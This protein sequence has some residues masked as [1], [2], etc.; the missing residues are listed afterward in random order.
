MVRDRHAAEELVQ[1]TFVRAWMRLASLRNASAFPSWLWSIGRNLA[2]TRLRER[3]RDESDCEADMDRH[4]DPRSAPGR[5]PVEWDQSAWDRL[6]AGLNRD[7]RLLLELRHVAG[8]SLREIGAVLGIPEQRVK[9]RLFS[10]RRRLAVQLREGLPRPLPHGTIGSAAFLEETIMDIIQTQRLGAHVFMRLSLAIQSEMASQVIQGQ[11][12]GQSVLSAIGQV[13][14]GPEFIAAYGATITLPE[15]IGILNNVDRFTER[16][17]V[18]H[19]EVVAPDQAE[20]IKQNM[21]VFE[22]IVLFDPLAIRLLLREADPDIFVT[23]LAG[24]E[25]KVRT[26]VLDALDE[27]GR[28]ELGARLAGANSDFNLALAA[29]EAVVNCIKDLERT[30]KLRIYRPDELPEGQVLITAK[31]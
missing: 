24:T 10:L 5:H 18:E 28:R 16:R 11:S 20:R 3:Q 9:S 2:R 15:L 14:R 7:Q 19:L 6:S 17:L 26:H 8:L 25:I 1:E 21:F 30:G 22:D 13:D 4:A 23:A 12:F 29:Q 27:A 31:T